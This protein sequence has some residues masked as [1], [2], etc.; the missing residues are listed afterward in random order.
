MLIKFY[1]NNL[2]K[3]NENILIKTEAQFRRG[4]RPRARRGRRGTRPSFYAK[5]VTCAVGTGNWG[6]SPF[7]RTKE[8]MDSFKKIG[9]KKH[10]CDNSKLALGRDWQLGPESRCFLAQNLSNVLSSSFF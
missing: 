4:T 3:F 2:M 8:R 6:Q 7:L 1:K 9:E 5:I 10:K